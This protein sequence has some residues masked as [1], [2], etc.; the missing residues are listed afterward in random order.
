MNFYFKLTGAD[1]IDIIIFIVLLMAYIKIYTYSKLFYAVHYFIMCLQIL[2]NRKVAFLYTKVLVTPLH[3]RFASLL[4]LSAEV[5]FLFLSSSY[6]SFE[7]MSCHRS[8]SGLFS[9]RSIMFNFFSSNITFLI[10]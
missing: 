7:F 3:N 10:N 1:T 8:F 4:K 6:Y 2:F 9:M 5:I